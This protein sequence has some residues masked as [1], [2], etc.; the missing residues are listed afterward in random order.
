MLAINAS[1]VATYAPRGELSQKDLIQ[2]GKD[3]P[4]SFVRECIK[5]IFE[6]FSF[7]P[8]IK[9]AMNG[10]FADRAVEEINVYNHQFIK[11]NFLP[12]EEMF[13][14]IKGYLETHSTSIVDYNTKFYKKINEIC[15][16][17]DMIIGIH[18]GAPFL[19]KAYDLSSEKERKE[20]F[21]A[22]IKASGL[23]KKSKVAK[24]EKAVE[25]SQPV[26]PAKAEEKPQAF[27][28]PSI[29]DPLANSLPL[30]DESPAP[31]VKSN[32]DKVLEAV[33]SNPSAFTSSLLVE[34]CKSYLKPEQILKLDESV[35][36][37]S[38]FIDH[39]ALQTL[40]AIEAEAKNEDLQ[41]LTNELLELV[42][43]E[44]SLLVR[45]QRQ[46]EIIPVI[47]QIVDKS[48]DGAFIQKNAE[49][50]K[51]ANRENPGLSA[52]LGVLVNTAF[53]PRV[54][55]FVKVPAVKLGVSKLFDDCFVKYPKLKDDEKLIRQHTDIVLEI[56]VPI[57]DKLDEEYKI[58][59]QY[60]VG[61]KI[62]E[63]LRAIPL[64]E[65]EAIAFVKPLVIQTSM[66]N[67]TRLFVPLNTILNPIL[68]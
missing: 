36:A 41:K 62:S 53:S 51:K 24:K 4:R 1:V 8:F 67:L 10:Y 16:A 28:E 63:K 21:D 49:K 50:V 35:K 2:I 13:A 6:T 39:L 12:T 26:S 15:K 52:V 68:K 64:N 30:K 17:H 58:A 60:A 42:G 32:T 11:D 18:E 34:L 56:L 29:E 3:L 66:Q 54:A 25:A 43:K 37:L 61:H 5:K 31:A 65:E 38:P 19:V 48:I 7:V 9:K 55:D 27:A 59:D 20:L 45:R 46:Q 44:E 40:N 47:Q 22:R 23:K 57:L 14:S 33:I